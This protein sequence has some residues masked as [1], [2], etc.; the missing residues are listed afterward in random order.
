MIRIFIIFFLLFIGCKS[1]KEEYYYSEERNEIEYIK[2]NLPTIEKWDECYA[3]ESVKLYFD[4]LQTYDNIKIIGVYLNNKTFSK[5][6]SL[7]VVDFEDYAVFM[8]NHFEQKWKLSGTDLNRMFRIQKREKGVI[9]VSKDDALKKAYSDTTFL[10]PKKPI[11]IEEYRP[12]KNIL[13]AIKLLKPYKDDHEIII[14]FIFNM[15]IVKN[16]L[17]F[18]GYY[19]DFNG[20]ESIK[21]AKMNNDKIMTKFLEV[22]K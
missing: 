6:D 12:N 18:A 22:N 5:K 19:M 11:V 7:D 1:E 15:I 21:K 4:D 8:I 16:H 14:V 20:T 9:N 10:Q 13:S 17:I 2:F 3:D